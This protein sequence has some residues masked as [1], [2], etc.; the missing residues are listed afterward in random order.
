METTVV[1]SI[2][3]IL[4]FLFFLVGCEK[5]AE[6]YNFSDKEIKIILAD[7][8]TSEAA[9]QSVFGKRKDSLRQVYMDDIYLIHHTDSMKIVQLLNKLREDPEKLEIIYQQLLDEMSSIPD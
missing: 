9:L 6:P 7:I 8:H 3:Y 4:L 2:V 1:R 5:K